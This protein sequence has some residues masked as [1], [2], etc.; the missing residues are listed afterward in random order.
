MYVVLSRSHL[1]INLTASITR[2]LEDRVSEAKERESNPA[3]E[4]DSVK[5]KVHMQ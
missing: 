1:F 4:L 2:F 3:C 5:H